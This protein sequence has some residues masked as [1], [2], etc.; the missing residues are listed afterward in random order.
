MYI[1]KLTIKN[2][3]AF[4]EE[5]QDGSQR[6]Y[7]FNF[8]PNLNCIAGHNGIGKST[9]LAILNNVGEL[10]KKHGQHLNGKPFRGEYS[11]LIKGNETFDTVGEKIKV[12]FSDRPKNGTLEDSYPESLTFRATFQ[13]HMQSKNDNKHPG[14]MKRY[15]LIPKR[16]NNRK[17]ESKLTFP[18]FYLGLSRLYPIGESKKTDSKKINNAL[19]NNLL[20]D[21]NKLLGIS[22]DV[23][24]NAEILNI[25]ETNN[26]SGFGVNT[27]TYNYL[28]NSAGQDNLGQILLA[29]Y[30]FQELKNK[31]DQNYFGGVLLID[32]I[33][34]TLHPGVQNKLIDYLLVKSKELKLQIFFTT[35]SN[36]LLEHLI[37]I[38]ELSTK[39]D[40]N[41]IHINFLDNLKKDI[42]IREN[43]SK[44]FI[45]NN[46]KETYTTITKKKVIHIVTEDDVAENYLNHI[47]EFKKFPFADNI[48][49]IKSSNSWTTLMKLFI[50]EPKAFSNFIFVLDP[51]L[52]AKEMEE[53]LKKN[54]NYQIMYLGKEI[55]ILPGNLAIE[56]LIWEWIKELDYTSPI[57]YE[58]IMD[59]QSIGIKILKENG[60]TDESLD[61]IK[62][63]YENNMQFHNIFFDYYIEENETTINQFYNNFL[64]QF[65]KILY[66]K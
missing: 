16:T 59:Q 28:A 19:L 3:R 6:E 2:F 48:N 40:E 52:N 43:P 37:K 33:D 24:M 38:R 53:I 14:Q 56:K 62:K 65:S 27:D 35:H 51:D 22:K 17:T 46:L 49:F 23:K 10:K 29:I 41:A 44:D 64:K 58:D 36:T 1:N 13:K 54:I 66:D 20:K 9:L 30:S 60:P 15:R 4:S 57:F 45:T 11:E 55:Q 7:T 5:H 12:Y 39:K 61:S 26:K 34:A 42:Q 25:S 47:L 18:T 50:A 8:S 63:W 32:E 31:L 21:Y